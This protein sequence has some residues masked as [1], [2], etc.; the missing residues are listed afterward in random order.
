MAWASVRSL[1]CERGRGSDSAARLRAGS[2]G[3]Q[4]DFQLIS[5]LMGIKRAAG[6]VSSFY[7]DRRDFPAAI[8]DAK[9]QL[10][11]I[12]SFVNID[13]PEGN[14]PLPEKLLHSPAVAAPGGRIDRKF[15]ISHNRAKDPRNYL[16]I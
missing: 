10:F 4:W 16:T 5:E 12:R 14:V 13:F 1:K 3:I 6:K 11:R 7:F 15:A 8:V 2:L 9:H